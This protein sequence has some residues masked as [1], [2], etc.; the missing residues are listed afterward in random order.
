MW[1]PGLTRLKF[2]ISKL[3][4][5]QNTGYIA[6]N[7]IPGLIISSFVREWVRQ[8]AQ[9]SV[10]NLCIYSLYS[11]RSKYIDKGFIWKFHWGGSFHMKMVKLGILGDF[12]ILNRLLGGAKLIFINYIFKIAYFSIWWPFGRHLGF[13]AILKILNIFFSLAPP[14]NQFSTQKYPSRPNFIIFIWKLP[15]QF[16]IDLFQIFPLSI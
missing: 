14:R 6:C 2:Y 1:S 10:Q 3:S 15:P 9:G 11:Y 4:W 8:D 12:C 16:N 7:F 5:L 13:D